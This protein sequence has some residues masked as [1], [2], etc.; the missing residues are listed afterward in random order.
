MLCNY[1]VF[2][3]TNYIYTVEKMVM[4]NQTEQKQNIQF[5][6]TRVGYH[7]SKILKNVGLLY[8]VKMSTMIEI[9]Q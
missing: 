8:F 3:F 7:Y 2:T 4:I 5:K 6:R 9:L 1:L